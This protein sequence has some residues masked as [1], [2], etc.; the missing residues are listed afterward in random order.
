MVTHPLT[1]VLNGEGRVTGPGGIDCLGTSTGV[2]G[3]CAAAISE[4][5]TVTLTQSAAAG[6]AFVD[7]TSACTGSGA[8]TF[9]MDAAKS[10]TANFDGPFD[11]TL[12]TPLTQSLSL[13]IGETRTVPVTLTLTRGGALPVALTMSYP[14]GLMAA[15]TTPVTP[16]GTATI[17]FTATQVTSGPATVMAVG[18][19]V[20]RTL[21]LQVDA[22]TPFGLEGGRGI[23]LEGTG[24]TA[25]ITEVSGRLVRVDTTTR[26]IVKTITSE[27]GAA[28]NGVAIEPGGATALVTHGGGLTRVTLATGAL[29]TLTTQLGS[30]YGVALEAGG[31]TALVTDASRLVRVTLSSG[32]V[33]PIA[34]LNQPY[35]VAL[36]A[37]GTTALVGE[38][39]TGR[40]LRVTLAGGAVLMLASN[41]RPEGIVL[42]TG[43][44][45]VLVSS[46]GYVRRVRLATGVQTDVSYAPGQSGFIAPAATRGLA[47]EASGQ[48]ALV[49]Q[50]GPDRLVR[51]ALTW[52]AEAI[53]PARQSVELLHAPF[54]VAIE[55]SGTT[56]LVTGWGPSG[57]GNGRVSRVDLSTGLVNVLASGLNDPRGIALE[58][59]GATALVAERGAS[60]LVRVGLSG[61]G[62]TPL[63]APL[64]GIQY[65]VPEAGG[66]TAIVLTA[67]SLHRVTLSNGNR[68]SIAT[69]GGPCGAAEYALGMALESATTALVVRSCPAALVRVDLTNGSVTTV[70]AGIETAAAGGAA[71]GVVVDGATA[72]VTQN[73]GSSGRV[74]RVDLATGRFTV[75]ASALG[76]LRGLALLPS[77]A[78]LLGDLRTEKLLRVGEPPAKPSAIV[79]TLQNPAGF[80]LEADAGTALFVDCFGSATCMDGVG[81]LGRVNLSSGAV[82]TLATGFTAP[83]GVAVEASGAFA[84]ITDCGGGGAFGCTSAGRLLRVAL[85]TGATSLI[86]GALNDPD[87][88]AIEAGGATAIIAEVG[89]N[90]L[91]RV[92]LSTG[93]MSIFATGLRSPRD[94][95]IEPGGLT[96]LTNHDPGQPSDPGALVRIEIATGQRT[97]VAGLMV[98]RFVLEPSGATALVL[99]DGAGFTTLLL[100]VDL[101]TGG[102]DVRAPGWWD[103]GGALLLDGAGGLL[104]GERR[105]RT[106]SLFRMPIP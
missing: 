53:A 21:Q 11:F 34:T 39:G 63:S 64:S 96:V 14:P 104:F 12:G 56:A 38:I 71:S 5:A 2:T 8:C 15:I 48:S 46:D 45:T 61:G 98:N 77:G 73:I 76:D 74:L 19:G 83:A 67:D 78:V 103:A 40:L 36:E 33:A 6:W 66:A 52:P 105:P 29:Q 24:A 90:R 3:T 69:F 28:A 37:G 84:L 95:R 79:H 43:G 27:L 62:V 18:G 94:V 9:T 65:A 97:R 68:S 106:G 13:V 99:V 47:L 89:G 1:V 25:L 75:F 26:R 85:G 100:R 16:N 101:A 54:G 55:A 10:V 30:P 91:S 32:A 4:G 93:A 86:V 72:L 87:G 82:T 49:V 17:T 80:A 41:V 7:W 88:I 92:D 60:R 50:S 58:A 20:M 35:A 102:V 44:A 57:G 70:V 59:G 81:R 42:E 23:A 31:S 22:R 51:H